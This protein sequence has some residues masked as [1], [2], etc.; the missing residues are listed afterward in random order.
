MKK[1]LKK[2]RKSL[3]FGL[4]FLLLVP[5]G[6]FTA[7]VLTQP[8]VP[9]VPDYEKVTLTDESNYETIFLQTGLGKSAVNTL[10][11]NGEWSKIYEIQEKFF[12]E[13][14]FETSPIINF[15]TYEEDLKEEDKTQFIDLQKGDIL[16]TLS[17]YSLGWRHGHAG[18]VISE[19]SILEISK[20]GTLSNIGTTQVWCDF[21]TLA[22]LRVKNAD[23]QTR[24]DV[25]D[26]AVSSLKGK[27][28]NL[29]AGFGK[30]K[31]P[32]IEAD[33]LSVHCSYLPWYAWQYFGFDLD[34]DSG[35][36]VTVCDLLYS[37]KVEIVQLYGLDPREFTEQNSY[38]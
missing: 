31:A 25:A 14:E 3:L 19:N 18:L 37:D 10:K 21:S 7:V 5:I 4:A 15:F 30:V 13:K 6:V 17:T 32:K 35:R 38:N 33:N 26:F 11:A 9:F 1:K 36:I 23:E 16:I 28:Y 20:I 22:V 8:N 34:S 2:V 27:P 29:L 12:K 24:T